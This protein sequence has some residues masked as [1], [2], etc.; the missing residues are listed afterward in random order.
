MVMQSPCLVNSSALP[1]IVAILSE[2]SDGQWLA[3]AYV[4]RIAFGGPPDLANVRANGPIIQNRDRVPAGVFRFRGAPP[5]FKKPALIGCLSAVPPVL[6]WIPGATS[7]NLAFAPPPTPL[8]SPLSL[9]VSRACART[10]PVLVRV[11]RRWVV[12]GNSWRGDRSQ[13]YAQHKPLRLSLVYNRCVTCF[14]K[15]S[16]ERPQP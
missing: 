7:P 10:L 5:R 12:A 13:I 6:A 15:P 2:D 4:E 9:V 16:F 8:S 1:A 3:V 14:P 11:C